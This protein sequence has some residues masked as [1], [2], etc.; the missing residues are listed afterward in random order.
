MRK[1]ILFFLI[2]SFVFAQ[3]SNKTYTFLRAGYQAG[4]V[5]QTSEFLQGKNITGIPVDYFQ[6]ARLEFGWQTDGDANWHQVFNNPSYGIGFYGANFFDAPE[7]GTPSAV[8]GFF[9]WPFKRY[10]HSAISAEFGFGLAYDWEEFDPE[11]NPYNLVIGAAKS[12]YIDVGIKYTYQISRHL[13][14]SGQLSFSH[15]SNGSTKQPNAGINLI[16]PR[17]NLAYNFQDEKPKFVKRELPEFKTKYEIVTSLT[18]GS[19]SDVYDVI[20]PKTADEGA[21]KYDS[22][23]RES[24]DVY[25]FIATFNKQIS[26]NS[27]IGIG[28]DIAI[29]NSLGV[30][31]KY[32]PVTDEKEKIDS[33]MSDKIRIGAFFQYSL[34]IYNLEALVGIGYYIKGKTPG[35]LE[36][37]YQRL[38]G[39][40]YIFDNFSAGLNL[41]FYDFSRADNMEFNIG[42]RF[43][44]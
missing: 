39:R 18:Y 28:A 7:I 16:A 19:K 9:D 11:S 24:F 4:S 29:D 40:Y 44:L 42:Y 43:S 12:V 21:D 14:L 3:E 6:S 26:Y 33:E 13:D 38:G 30:Q 25:A 31:Y 2:S 41:R 36:K 34:V 23:R 27:K 32:N 8:Y 15:F 10:K 35:D 20:N 5:L 37:F 22:L 17:I 1:L